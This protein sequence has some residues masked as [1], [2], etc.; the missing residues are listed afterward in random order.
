ML[1]GNY[2]AVFVALSVVVA[3]LAS[4]A[5]LDLAGRVASATGN[6]RMGWVAGGA[7][8]MGLGIWSMHFVGMIAFRLPIRIAYDLPLML[9]S[10]LVAIGASLLA[11]LVVSQPKMG[12]ITLLLAGLMMGTAISGMH[13]IGMASVLVEARLSYDSLLVVVSIVIA[14]AASLAALWLAF[15]FRSDVSRRGTLLKGL[16][17]VVM[18][19]AIAG[20]HYTAMLAAR[21][22]PHAPMDRAP[23]YIVASGELGVAVVVGAIAI[24][25]LALIG[26][27]IDRNLQAR[28]AFTK[29]LHDK[30]T[31]LEKSERQYRLLF[32]HNPNPIWVYEQSS[33]AFLAVNEA[34]I[35][36]YGYTSNEFLSMS[37]G[38]IQPA[39][40][41]NSLSSSVSAAIEGDADEWREGRH[42][43]R[44]GTV[45]DVVLTSHPITFDG[46]EARLTLALD[47]TE[48][49]RSEEALRQGEKR[50]RELFE[51]M[52]VALYRSTPDGRFI[53]VNPAMVA[54]LGYPDRK[55]LLETSI[56]S[57]Y[58]DARERIRWSVEMQETGTVRDFEVR[59]RRHDGEVL[60]LRDTTHA[61]KSEN[62]MVVRYEGA[63]EDITQRKRLEDQLRQASKMEAV[64]QLAGGVAHDFNNLLMAIRGN[65]DILLEEE[66]EE[67]RGDEQNGSAEGLREI[68]KAADRAAMLTRQLLAFSRRQVLQPRSVNLNAVIGGM[69]NMLARLISEQIEVVTRL[70]PLVGDAMVDPTQVEQVIMNLAVNARD[71][72]P[73]GGT[74][75][76]ETANVV[77]TGE[78]GA[79]LSALGGG[80]FVQL[81][82]TDTG[83]GIDAEAMPH[84][85]EP[86]FTTKP[87]GQGTGLGLATVYGVVKQS[88]GHIWVETCEKKGTR[89]RV[90]FPRAVATAAIAAEASI[91]SGA[92]G[93][94]E[95]VLL[96]E[97]EA[98]VRRITKKLLVRLG[99]SVLEAECG[100]RALELAAAHRGTIDLLVTDIVMP[101]MRGTELARRVRETRPEVRVV[102]TSG[103][104]KDGLTGL[105]PLGRG[106]L[107]IQKPFEPDVFAATVRE[108]LASA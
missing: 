7:T 81:T 10:V 83:S 90:V 11:L 99:Y 39:E 96:V 36:Q 20:M 98:M 49:K 43:K 73:D 107:F 27:V 100:E 48:R 33:R 71:A 2:E 74:L 15:R 66:E 59:L 8:V 69:K 5:A 53:D 55:T 80:R 35:S 70:D 14:I 19:V 86:F 40:D 82:V 105:G 28:I 65:A 87:Q 91:D 108:A 93:G 37:V 61:N 64:G 101:R 75:T 79:G 9:L 3:M 72:M 34:A 22:G 52:P 18:G 58:V 24:I 88:G 54:L 106:T 32:D 16:S 31:E 6:A 23:H 25:I 50:Y 13:Y 78:E 76:L 46:R 97:D 21:F 77:L 94:M 47:V 29:Q 57:L 63:L 1:T 4:Y 67:G 51:N 85:F 102:Y 44:D 38:D 89:F 95:T 45:I 12:A 17:A 92:A 60:S 26:A 62:G 104:E 103:Y 42:R 68:R 30:T 84:I 56:P 41:L